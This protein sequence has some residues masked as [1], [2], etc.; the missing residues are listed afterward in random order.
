VF[1]QGRHRRTYAGWVDAEG[2]VRAGYY[3]HDT[4][5]VSVAPEPL[6]AVLD[7]N[8]TPDDHS[9]PAFLVLPDGRLQVFYSPHSGSPMWYRISKKPEDITSWGPERE[10]GVNTS[11]NS[12]YTYPNPMRLSGEGGMVYLFW[13][14]G[15]YKPNF[16][17]SMDGKQWEPARTLIQGSGARPYIK[18]ASDG[19]KAI[20]FAFTDGHPRAEETNNIY[21][22]RYSEGAFH[23]ADGTLIKTMEELPIAPTQAEL[24][25]NGAAGQGRAWIWDIALDGRNRPVIVY[26]AMPEKTRHSYRYARWTGER[27][28]ENQITPAGPWFPQTR[29]GASESEPHYSGGVVLDHADPSVVFLSRQVK[30]VFEIEKWST[31]DGGETWETQAITAGSRKNNVRPV[32]ARPEAG[33]NGPAQP[34]LMWMHGGYVHYTDYETTIKINRLETAGQ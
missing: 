4:G 33:G 29:P 5:R 31:A 22:A 10:L 14:G 11:G 12:G 15:N 8:G 13:R 18:F 6:R 25:Y 19:E 3:D 30:G 2:S 23:R 24:I 9:N 7:D 16:S 17:R 32:V 1:H 21:Y 34:L 28:Q 26:S 20:H 27:W